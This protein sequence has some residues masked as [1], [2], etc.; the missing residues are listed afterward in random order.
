MSRYLSITEINTQMDQLATNPD[1][2]GYVSVF[3]LN[4]QTAGSRF[5]KCLRIG[6]TT[7]G[8]TR[9]PVLIMGGIHAREWAPPDALLDFAQ[10]LLRC[11]H[12]GT[13]YVDPRFVMNTTNADANDLGHVGRVVFDETAPTLFSVP[14]VRRVINN[15]ELY[16]IPTVNPDGRDF[17]LQSGNISGMQMDAA[18]ATPVPK[19]FWRKNRNNLGTCTDGTPAIGVDLNRNFSPLPAWNIATYHNAAI[20]A[21]IPANLKVSVTMDS[22]AYAASP[23]FNLF[24]GTSTPENEVRNIIDLVNER[25]IKFFLDVH[26]AAREIYYPWS[27]NENQT[28]DPLKSQFNDYWD[29]IAGNPIAAQR[30][31]PLNDGTPNPAY[32]EFIPQEP[33]YNLLLRHVQLAN[34]M[35]NLIRD[36]AGSDIHAQ[37]R[38]TY[39]VK[40][41]FELYSSPGDSLDYVFSTQ[42]ERNP[43][44]TAAGHPARIKP[45]VFPVHAFTI[46]AGHRSDGHFWPS[47]A[48]SSNQYLKVRRE[49]QFAVIAL[50]KYAATW[51]VPVAPAPPPPPSG[52]TPPSGCSVIILIGMGIATSLCVTLFMLFS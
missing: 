36:A 46:E 12:A 47:R 19:S 33:P 41:S 37:N 40:Q 17:S 21:S 18:D 7:P 45:S 34:A 48:A 44:G 30:G 31:R 20:N 38:C 50:I 5:V 32:Q 27:M 26:S 6:S 4:H 8:V 16:I 10:R 14:D 23:F 49:V 15:L 22:S 1:Y 39:A 29:N 9:V 28:T 52:G 25:H 13:P 51:S 3:N 43:A 24:H 42:M 35:R 2:N 11:F